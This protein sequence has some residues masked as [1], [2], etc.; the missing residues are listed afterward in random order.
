MDHHYTV[1]KVLK[2][3][4]SMQFDN[5]ATI[6]VISRSSPR[7]HCHLS[8]WKS[9]VPQGGNWNYRLQ[10]YKTIAIQER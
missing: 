3:V 4:Q 2:R 10:Y 5:A 9:P 7:E 1:Q 8:T 6:N